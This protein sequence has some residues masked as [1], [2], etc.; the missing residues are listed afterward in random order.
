MTLEVG[1][2]R[3]TG[4]PLSLIALDVDYFKAIN[5]A[6]GHPTG[7]AVLRAVGAALQGSTKAFDLPARYGG[8]EFLVL[9]PG[10]AKSDVPGVA[11]RLRRAAGHA[12]KPG[13]VVTVSAGAAT[14][15]DDVEDGA[16]LITAAD[17]ALYAAKRAGRDRVGVA[18]R[19]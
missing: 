15:P 2:Q 1:R 13:V 5:D 8:D 12:V 10:C 11:E 16:A 4:A 19:I 14:L 18:H 6:H 9:L 7:D 3:R 17:A